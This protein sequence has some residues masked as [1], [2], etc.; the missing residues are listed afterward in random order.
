MYIYIYKM[1][2]HI[3]IYIY[4]R[5]TASC[6]KNILIVSV[7]IRAKLIDAACAKGRDNN[8][9]CVYICAAI[10][11]TSRGN[12]KHGSTLYIYTQEVG[13]NHANNYCKTELRHCAGKILAR[14][15][16]ERETRREMALSFI[17]KYI[18]VSTSTFA[19]RMCIT[20]R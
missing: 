15:C 11:R 10:T 16:R 17:A 6:M 5:C 3:C 2:V 18:S 20:H 19:C 13:F 9:Y 7:K 1:F 12:I 8:I 4:R 14:F